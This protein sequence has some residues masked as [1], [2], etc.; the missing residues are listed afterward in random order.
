MTS[1]LL[2]RPS[3]EDDTVPSSFLAGRLR[4]LAALPESELI[5][6]ALCIARF[7]LDQPSDLRRFKILE[8]LLTYLTLRPDE[9]RRLVETLKAAYRALEI[10]ELLELIDMERDV[11]HGF[12]AD[13]ASRTA[14]LIPWLGDCP[15]ALLSARNDSSPAVS[16]L[17]AA[18]NL[19][20]A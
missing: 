13:E 18:L 8:R 14:A 11:L 15:P 3:P 19:K 4:S 2:N 7:E 17:A 12:T 1:L 9:A 5:D 10:E 16:F 6:E 20:Q